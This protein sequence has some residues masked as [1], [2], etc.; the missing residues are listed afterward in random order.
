[1]FL[2]LFLDLSF[3]DKQVN[4]INNELV[5]RIR[6]RDAFVPTEGC[7]FLAAGK[8]FNQL[9]LIYNYLQQKNRLLSN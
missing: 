4:K 9:L 6:V 3:V 8:Y 5:V 2:F 7:I 1:M